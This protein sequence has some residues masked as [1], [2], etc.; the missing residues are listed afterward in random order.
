MREGCRLN[1]I[2]HARV[3]AASRLRAARDGRK[4]CS[5]FIDLIIEKIR[6][7]REARERTRR[8]SRAR[9][10]DAGHVTLLIENP[11]PVPAVPLR[12]CLYP[13]RPL[14][15]RHGNNKSEER[16]NKPNS[17]SG[18][19]ST[20][21]RTCSVLTRSSRPVPSRPVPS[22]P[23]RR[24][25]LF[26]QPKYFFSSDAG[27]ERVVQAGG[28]FLLASLHPSLLLAEPPP[29][30]PRRVSLSL[31]LSL[32]AISSHFSSGSLSG[33]GIP[34][35]STGAGRLSK[36]LL[37]GPA[38]RVP[39]Q[40]TKTNPIT[41]PPFGAPRRVEEETILRRADTLSRPIVVPAKPRQDFSVL[42]LGLAGRLV[43]GSARI[44]IIVIIV[45]RRV[46]SLARSLARALA[47]ERCRATFPLLPSIVVMQRYDATSLLFQ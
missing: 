38:D 28:A 30:P 23:S 2:F 25:S 20:R 4:K 5:S 40:Q 6:D 41:R 47:R 33:A 45:A 10:R 3:A 37:G 21:A 7:G 16:G 14:P 19:E 44:A 12:P 36:W 35:H 15:A 34:R 8:G 27:C 26:R 32:P 39:S 43:A 11:I 18:E 9:A 42:R 13:A 31:S 1:N 46:R 22:R 29:P 24:P 17:I